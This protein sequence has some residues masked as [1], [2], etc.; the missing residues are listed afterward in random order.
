[1]YYHF[2]ALGFC[3]L[4]IA[5]GFLYRIST[6]LFF[7]GFTYIFLLDKT[8][9]LNHFYLVSLLS[10]IMIFMPA[11]KA[12][13]VD[14]KLF[15]KIKSDWVPN[16]TLWWLRIQLGIPYF[17]G[18]IAKINSDWLRCEPMRMWLSDRTDFPIIGQWFTQEWMV[19]VFS[20]GGL[21]LDLLIVPFLIY[22]KTRI[23]AFLI[24]TCFHVMNSQLFGI[25]IFPW[26]MIAATTIFFPAE[27]F[28]FWKRSENQSPSSFK[29][30]SYAFWGL[31]VYVLIQVTVPFRH[32][33]FKGN[34]NWTEEGH[35]F[36]W[37]MK[38]RSKSS[39]FSVYV[40]D[41][42]TK[43]KKQIRLKHYLSKRQ[44]RKIKSKPDMILQF[45]H[46]LATKEA[47]RGKKNVAIYVDSRCGLNGRPKSTFIDPQVDLS[48]I[49]YPFYK[50]ADW[51][52]PLK[53]PLK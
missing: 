50:K 38:L 49:E 52:V 28:R 25:G 12:F 11:N 4:C 32:H 19:Y 29:I 41:N 23:P 46:H 10:F 27:K 17:F 9:Y 51:I 34:V 6:I 5:I 18:G 20:Y 16:W 26:F 37:H 45:A 53:T 48:T 1:M 15:P 35:R 47:E 44:R 31:A 13:S 14:A 33:L 22:K 40:I 39:K 30:S 42:D 36:S 3:A 7:L 24:I 2:Y 43:A 21:L 8:N